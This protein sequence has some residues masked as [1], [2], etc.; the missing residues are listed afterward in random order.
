MVKNTMGMGE[1]IGWHRPGVL[2]QKTYFIAVI[3]DWLAV[4]QSGHVSRPA[5]MR[6]ARWTSS[7]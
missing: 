6:S 1:R 3:A 4:N 5:A 7:Q 2:S